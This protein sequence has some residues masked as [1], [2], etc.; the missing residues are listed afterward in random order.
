MFE[1]AGNLGL[2]DE[3]LNKIVVFR[4][5]GEHAFDRDQVGMTTRI[6]GLGTINFCHAAKG[7]SV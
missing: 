7:D 3:H 4:Q 5:V 1:K 6:E 2:V